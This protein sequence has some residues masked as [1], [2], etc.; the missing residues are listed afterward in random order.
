MNEHP[1]ILLAEYADGTLTPQAEAEVEAHLAECATCREELALA[2]EARA[3]LGSLPEV[4]A[5]EGLT[6]NVR[7]RAS[8]PRTPRL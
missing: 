6:L 3:A 5:P 1:E 8:R 4:P 7:R 2:T